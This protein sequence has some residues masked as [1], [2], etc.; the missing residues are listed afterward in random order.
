VLALTVDNVAIGNKAIVQ[1]ALTAYN[2]LSAN[3]KALL[4][5]E[6]AL[7]DSLS[8]Q[9]A[10]L[11]ADGGETT[12][13]AQDLADAFSASHSTALALTVDNVAIGNKAI[14][15]AAL[16]AYNTLDANVKALLATERVL[17]DSLLEKIEDLEAIENARGAAGISISFTQPGDEAITLNSAS[18]IVLKASGGSLTVTITQTFDSYKW[19]LDGVVQTGQSTG[20]VSI[21]AASLTTGKHTLTAVVYRGSKPYSKMLTFTV[22][23]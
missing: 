20:A 19:Y 23:L 22:G 5:T 13:T 11:E 14:V 1:A 10:A 2:T 8:D 17:L 12:P 18:E 9:I 15:Q 3:V 21:A 7:L 6:K 4:A 16:T